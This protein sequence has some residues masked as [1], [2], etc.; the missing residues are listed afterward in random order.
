MPTVSVLIPAYNAEQYLAQ[1]VDSALKQTYGDSEIIVV[2]DG[3]TDRT[4]EIAMAYGSEIV[5]VEHENRGLGR[6]R[7][8]ALEASSGEFISLL[9]SD[10][11][12]P[13]DR[14][15]KM[16]AFLRSNPEVGWATSDAFLVRGD[17]PTSETFYGRAPDWG[18]RHSD[19]QYW[20]TQHN[21]VQIHTVIRR[22]LFERHG[23]FDDDGSLRAVED[24][25]LWIRF[26]FAGERV[27]LVAEPLAFYRLRPGSLSIDPRSILSSEI[28]VLNKA[29]QARP[30]HRGLEGRLHYSRAKRELTQA[31]FSAASEE[32]AM[33]A[34]DPDLNSVMRKRA[35]LARLWPRLARAVYFRRVG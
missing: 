15:E 19:Q 17:R 8:S 31:N 27:G 20:I 22:E 29:L 4:G 30:H 26:L 3:S 10:D 14:L 25:D 23:R 16:V 6:A 5:Y 32:F 35:R 18:F 33:A 12:W 28:A 7:N 2:N 1:A 34:K 11:Y 9:D 21:F 24:W 13:P